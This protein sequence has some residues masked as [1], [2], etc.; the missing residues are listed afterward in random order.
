MLALCKL[1]PMH[2]E[3]THIGMTCE[4]HVQPDWCVCG[5]RSPDGRAK[6][7]VALTGMHNPTRHMRST[8]L[9]VCA[10]PQLMCVNWACMQHP[11]RA[12]L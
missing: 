1:C 5:V 9:A 2:I 12:L 4:N 10:V 3:T 6:V 8:Q 11:N 7:A